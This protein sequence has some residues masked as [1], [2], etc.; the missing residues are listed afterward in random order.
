MPSTLGYEELNHLRVT[1]IN[2]VELQSL[3]DVPGA[4]AKAERG[5]HRIEFDT[6]PGVI[7]L[8]AASVK[9]DEAALIKNYRLPAT[10]RL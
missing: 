1:K 9:E 2:S 5:L 3:A 4:L 7:F 6:D 10:T 8:D